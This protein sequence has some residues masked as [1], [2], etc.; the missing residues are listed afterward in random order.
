MAWLLISKGNAEELMAASPKLERVPTLYLIS[1]MDSAVKMGKFPNDFV[2]NFWSNSSKK[3]Q[4]G[5]LPYVELMK[6]DNVEISGLAMFKGDKL[7][8][9]TQ[10]LEIGAYMG[11]KG[12]NPAGYRGI[13]SVGGA[14]NTVTLYATHRKAKID[15]Q[16]KNG[17]P[18]FT[19]T[20]LNELNIEEKISDQFLIE[21]PEIIKEIEREDEKAAIKL[22][23]GLVKETQEKGSD[24]FGFGEYVRAKEPKFWNEQVQTKE[25]WQEMY[26][27]VSVDVQIDIKVRRVGMK[28]R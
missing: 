5:L 21:N 23:E 18:H 17:L 15:V 16:I 25:H 9:I 19:V 8:G 28:A 13:I 3:G 24:I 22:H 1:T 7:V 6:E 14:Q 10:P 2:G 12:M 26:K 4:E 11:I 27:D 20:I